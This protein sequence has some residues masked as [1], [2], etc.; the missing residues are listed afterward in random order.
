MSSVYKSSGG[1]GIQGERP[2]S[3]SRRGE[4]FLRR[5]SEDEGRPSNSRRGERFLRRGSEDEG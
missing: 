1:Q 2:C 4:R 5:G 3:T